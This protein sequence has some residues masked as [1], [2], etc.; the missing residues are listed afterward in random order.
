[1]I[2]VMIRELVTLLSMFVEDL[3]Q[4][5][6]NVSVSCPASLNIPLV[7]DLELASVPHQHN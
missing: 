4:F 6:E 7:S 1:M 5:A 3:L 2:L